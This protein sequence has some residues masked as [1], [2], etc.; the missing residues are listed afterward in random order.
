MDVRTLVESKARAARQ[1][2][3]V[4]A[5]C[6]ARVKNEALTQMARGLEEKTPALLEAN[7][8]DLDRAR[9]KGHTR[10]FLDRLTLTEPRVETMAAG[11]REIAAL[12]DPVGAVVESWRRPNGIEISRVRVPLG[13][14]GFIYESRPNVTA[15]AAGLCVK[16]G[17]AVVLRGGSEAIE[18]NALIAAVLAK[19]MEK[20]GAPPEAI[21]FIDVAD[22]AA[23]AVMLEQDRWL[24]LVIPRG[25]EDFVRWVSERSRVPVLKHD[26]GVVHVFVDGGADLDM[27]ASIVLNAK[28]HRPSVCNALETL[29]VDGALAGRFL[30]ALATRLGEAG[31]EVRGCPRSRALVPAWG[32]ATDADWDAEYLDLVLAVRVVDGLEAAI[33][34]IGR[35]GSGLAEAI[36]TNDLAHA[37]RFTR[38]VD[39]AAVLVNASTRLVDGQ[40]FGMGAEMGISTSRVHA[41]GPVGVRELTTTKFIVQGDGQVRE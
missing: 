12:P 4:L 40:Q 28:T 9:A 14:I 3:R 32:A 25:G 19:A 5:L 29:L 37:R 41:R 15:D 17:N 6:S 39:A 8:A 11:L 31:V 27:A 1:A 34:H 20:T 38:E 2:A 24:D 13:V 7:H 30:P 21:Q 26:K 23:V 35:H 16:S 22:R 36:V 33:E 18:S 10:A